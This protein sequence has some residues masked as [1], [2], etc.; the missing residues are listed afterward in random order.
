MKSAFSFLAFCPLFSGRIILK[1][2]I[3]HFLFLPSSWHSKLISEVTNFILDLLTNRNRR[4][5]KKTFVFWAELFLFRIPRCLDFLHFENRCPVWMFI[6]CTF[7]WI[8]ETTVT[9]SVTALR[10]IC[11][12]P[13]LRK[14]FQIFSWMNEQS[15][16]IFSSGFRTCDLDV[17]HYAASRPFLMPENRHIEWLKN[18]C[19]VS[20]KS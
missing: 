11:Q 12:I 5:R 18:A 8:W 2:S 10:F 3:A 14:A 17:M 20:M 7:T 9:S 6:F 13:V 1:Y 15:H 19:S 16:K 4:K